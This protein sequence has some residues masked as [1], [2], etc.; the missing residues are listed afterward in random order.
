M[1]KLVKIMLKKSSH[2]KKY[3]QFIVRTFTVKY[4]SYE[5]YT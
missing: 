4:L 5:N 2:Q 1:L 3:K